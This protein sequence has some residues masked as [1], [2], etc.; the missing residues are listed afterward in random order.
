[1]AGFDNNSLQ[2]LALI[3]D[4]QNKRQ[5][6]A[7]ERGYNESM[8]RFQAEQRKYE[9]EYQDAI[10]TRDF[11]L[12]RLANL[13][14]SLSSRG[15]SVP[16]F[17]S[18]SQAGDFVKDVSNSL[19]GKTEAAIGMAD[20]YA[21]QVS[22]MQTAQSA[23]VQGAQFAGSFQPVFTRSD[24]GEWVMTNDDG[25]DVDYLTLLQTAQSGSTD[26]LARLS[27]ENIEGMDATSKSAYIEGIRAS[28][29]DRSEESEIMNRS[30]NMF[31]S[32]MRIKDAAIDRQIKQN[33]LSGQST[34]NMVVARQVA[35]SLIDE[36]K[37][38]LTEITSPVYSNYFANLN[39][40]DKQANKRA[41]R[42]DVEL[43]E[44]ATKQWGF[45]NN[46][47]VDSLGVDINDQEAMRNAGFD[48]EEM[49]EAYI[50]TFSEA[51]S[52]LMI[53]PTQYYG[54]I[55]NAA[56]S[57]VDTLNEKGITLEQ[58]IQGGEIRP[59][60]IGVVMGYLTNPNNNLNFGNAMKTLDMLVK[61]GRLKRELKGLPS[62]DLV[63][64][65]EREILD[66][67]SGLELGDALL[68]GIQR[69]YRE[70]QP[71]KVLD[72]KTRPTYVGT[73]LSQGQSS[74][75]GA[76]YTEGSRAP[77][78]NISKYSGT[79]LRLARGFGEEPEIVD[80]AYDLA[81]E[82]GLQPAGARR[83][84]QLKEIIAKIKRGEIK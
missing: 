78:L 27:G 29:L 26:E 59:A 15:V 34:D 79:I 3:L 66:G 72:K 80:M 37:K 18:D 74:P 6:R 47:F 83:N 76:S 35:S 30:I 51:A 20:E 70:S 56:L 28:I 44:A 12:Q 31:E 61:G 58:A 55:E 10:R 54:Q 73:G 1:M 71:I 38:G 67:S 11:N 49:K 8:T 41:E 23:Y 21:K 64:Q 14:D 7:A 17:G 75:F 57:I 65:K 60:D 42:F 19:V 40:E 81:E 77:R 36:Y 48:V 62:A 16:D 43:M 5:D 50:K 33:Q 52:S 39:S 46:L 13:S 84:E 4:T 22:A 68:T 45:L 24:D 69:M 82:N 63:L 53:N 2:T 9:M 32:N 25:A